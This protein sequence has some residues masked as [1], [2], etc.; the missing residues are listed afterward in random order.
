LKYLDKTLKTS[1]KL[2]DAEKQDKVV[3]QF[4]VRKDGRTERFKLMKASDINT[5][6]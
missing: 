2:S 6:D 4:V 5:T 3:V 1:K